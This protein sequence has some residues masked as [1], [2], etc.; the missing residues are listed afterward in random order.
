MEIEQEDELLSKTLEKQAVLAL[1]N[2]NLEQLLQIRQDYKRLLS[3]KKFKAL[4]DKLDNS[5]TQLFEQEKA[6]AKVDD[7]ISILVKYYNDKL[8]EQLFKPL[9]KDN[10]S[11]IIRRFKLS[12]SF[13]NAAANANLLNELADFISPLECKE[14]IEAFSENSQI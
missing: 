9:L 4:T 14:I 13:D 10:I 3:K 2:V 12:S 6:K 7:F 1:D 8:F 11:K 5:V